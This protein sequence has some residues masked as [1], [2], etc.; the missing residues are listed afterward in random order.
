MNL[1]HFN[2]T[3]VSMKTEI[4]IPKPISLEGMMHQRYNGIF[5]MS[6]GTISTCNI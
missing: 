3:V 1:V 4:N 5:F 2:S 6:Q